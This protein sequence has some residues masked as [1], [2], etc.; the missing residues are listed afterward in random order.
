MELDNLNEQSEFKAMGKGH[1]ISE[2]GNKKLMLN[3]I[4]WNGKQPVFDL[5]VWREQDGKAQAT[6]GILLTEQEIETLRDLLNK[7]QD[8][9]QLFTDAENQL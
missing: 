9:K 7:H 8:I 2:S 6:K 3:F 5:R 1:I 4:S